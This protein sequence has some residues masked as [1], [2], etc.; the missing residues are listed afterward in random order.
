MGRFT[1]IERWRNNERLLAP[2]E[3]PLKILLKWGEY[4]N[5]VQFILQRSDQMKKDEKQQH[6]FNTE[7]TTTS[8][9]MKLSLNIENNLMDCTPLDRSKEFRKS[10]GYVI[11]FL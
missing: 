10:F 7:Q 3:N 5:D 4:A 11:L 2:T 9:S 8:T 6:A 1:L